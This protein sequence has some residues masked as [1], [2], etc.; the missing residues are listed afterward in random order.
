MA[1]KDRR[2]FVVS[3]L[4]KQQDMI[5]QIKEERKIKNIIGKALQENGYEKF[6]IADEDFLKKE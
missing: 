3:V 4:M 1:I 2:D 5:E 6:L